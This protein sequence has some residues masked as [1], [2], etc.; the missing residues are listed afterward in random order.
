MKN[1]IPVPE[2]NL[3][4]EDITN[5][6]TVSVPLGAGTMK[7]NQIS[8]SYEATSAVRA[9]VSYRIGAKTVDEELLLSSQ[10]K[11]SSMLLDGYLDRKTASRLISVRFEPIVTGENCVLSVSDFACCLQ[12]VPKDDVLFIE[13]EHYKAGVNLKWGGGLSWFEDK[14]N[15]DYG[16]LLNSHD[17]GRLVQQSYYG[18]T[19]IEGYENGV[20]GNTVWGYNPVQGGDQYGNAS[21]LVAV[22]KSDDKI[23]VVCRPLDWAQDNLFTQTYYTSVYQ[24][25]D[26]GLT[27]KNMAAHFFRTPCS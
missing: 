10:S 2:V 22:E 3:P 19:A 6:N 21:K 9:V 1:E 13:N 20:F 27:V 4:A 24:L 5:G 17:T 23:R 25:T 8:F 16:N 7:F 18:P 14:E 12:N 11:T 26:N 15:G